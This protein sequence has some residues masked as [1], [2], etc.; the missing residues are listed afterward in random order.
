MDGLGN[1]LLARA[2]FPLEQNCNRGI[3]QT[4]DH[5]QDLLYSGTAANNGVKL[6]IAV[7]GLSPGSRG[8]LARRCSLQILGNSPQ[9][10]IDFLFQGWPAV[11]VK[12]TTLVQ[13][14]TEGTGDQD[15]RLGGYLPGAL[16]KSS[17][18]HA[19]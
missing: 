18:S 14:R 1:Q 2:G 17:P 16:Q 11:L 4:P 9:N 5:F 3:L 19:G 13:E 12:G 15:C 8:G 7:T 10:R 6:N